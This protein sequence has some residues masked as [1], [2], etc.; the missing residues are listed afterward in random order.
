MKDD[1]N[2]EFNNEPNENLEYFD[3]DSSVDI[4]EE[5]YPEEEYVNNTPFQDSRNYNEKVE[6]YIANKRESAKERANRNN[7][8]NVKNAAEVA[9]NIPHPYAKAAGHIVSG[10]DKVTGGKSSKLLGKAVTT[11]NR[12]TPGGKRIQ[13]ALNRTNESG[14]GNLVGK[15]ASIKS[16]SNSPTGVENANLIPKTANSLPSNAPKDSSQPKKSGLSNATK[17]VGKLANK[18][19]KDQ[20]KSIII[21]FIA[22]NPYVLLVIGIVLFILFIILIVASNDNSE[23]GDRYGLGGYNYYNVDNLCETVTVYQTDEDGNITRTAEVDFEREY[24]PGVVYAE[25]GY[26]ADNIDMGKL[27]AIAA[28]SYALNMLSDDCEIEGSAR[29]QAF[30]FDDET[31]NSIVNNPN[32]PIMKAVNE[33]YGLVLVKNGELQTCYYDAACYRGEEGDNYLIG[34]GSL[35]LGEE[36]TQLIPKYWAEEQSGLMYYINKA[37]QENKMCYNNHGYGISQYGAYYLATEQ[38]YNYEQLLEFYFGPSEIYSIY[39]SN[40]DLETSTGSNNIITAD[41]ETVLEQNGTSVEALNE[42]I[43]SEIVNIGFGTRGAAVA[44][45]TSLVGGLYQNYRI[46]LPY[47]LCGQ[48][49]CT[50]FYDESDINVNRPGNNFYGVDPKWGTRIHNQTS[51]GYRFISSEYDATYTNYGPDC[52][53]F[54]SWVLHN[55]GFD[56]TVLGADALGNLGTKTQ[57]NGTNIGKPGD[58]VYHPGHIMIIVGVDDSRKVY[59][60]AHAA[61]GADGVKINTLSFDSSNNY[62]VDM[63]DWYSKHSAHITADDFRNGYINGYSGLESGNFKRTG[64]DK[65]VYFVGDSRTVGMCYVTKLCNETTECDTLSCLAKVGS[66]KS[67]FRDHL[68]NIKNTTKGNIVINMGVNDLVSGDPEKIADSYFDY[69][70]EIANSN[71]ERI[72][73]IM[74]VNPVKDISSVDPSS[75][76]EFNNEMQRLVY[77]SGASNIRYINTYNSIDFEFEGDGLHYK[78]STYQK[79]Y[80][81]VMGVI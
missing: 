18:G 36:H 12:F 33:T 52:S 16:G 53:G 2:K 17:L 79:I 81:Y 58:L 57:F 75:V 30:L 66:G 62:V 40:Y 49:Y 70:I 13:R 39:E 80:D 26:F 7:A 29:R 74:S 14:V 44:V 20:A 68:S 24:I 77:N 35:T 71:I 63:S 45:A 56:N 10:A 47:T 73:Y 15:A 78:F 55:A 61:N 64:I 65:G 5:Y 4:T 1:E 31:R 42:Y 76:V 11:A 51:G 21:K 59:Y 32:H 48:H 28:R 22:K 50:D 25:I 6:K 54:I 46:R 72:I 34:Y 37:R 3:D 43:L 60:V 67:W 8:Q 41:L 69:I 9:K 38:N 23:F 27:F 19:G